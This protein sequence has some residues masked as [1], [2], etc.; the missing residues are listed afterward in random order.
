M[1]AEFRAGRF[2]DGALVG[3]RRVNELLATHFPN[4]TADRNELPDK[5]VLL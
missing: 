2:E 3:I 5:P 4:P 1:E